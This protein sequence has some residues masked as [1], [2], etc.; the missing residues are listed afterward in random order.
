M[1]MIERKYSPDGTL[2]QVLCPCLILL[3]FP[4]LRCAPSLRHSAVLTD[5]PSLD[6]KSSSPHDFGN[7][8]KGGLGAGWWGWGGNLGT[9]A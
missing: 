2:R 1:F 9:R 5:F 6:I 7:C 4:L 8:R 3:F